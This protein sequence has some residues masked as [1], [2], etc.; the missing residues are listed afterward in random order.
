MNSDFSGRSTKLSVEEQATLRDYEGALRTIR[1][2]RGV[3]LLFLILSLLVHLAAF[4]SV[5]WGNILGAAA[6]VEAGIASTQ[7]GVESQEASEPDKAGRT[8]MVANLIELLLPLAEFVGQVSC[9]LLALCFLASAQVCLAGGL[10][11]VRGSLSAFFWMLVLLALLFPWARWF[12]GEYQVPGVF[13]AF[14]ELKDYKPESPNTLT[15][16]LSYLRFLGYPL[17]ALLIAF[18]GDSRYGRGYRLVRRH[19]EA[20]L[21]VRPI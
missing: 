20:R 12:H 18:V 16:V 21:Q 8:A 2:A 5:R 13:L 19:L 14:A 6:Q 15:Q 10:G 17:L 7:P 4:A 1:G 11:G 3:F 9:A